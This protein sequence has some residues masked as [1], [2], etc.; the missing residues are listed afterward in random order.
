MKRYFLLF[1]GAFLVFPVFGQESLNMNLLYNWEDPS[2]PP[3]SAFNNPYNEVWGYEADGHEYAIVASTLGTHILDITDTDNVTEVDFVPGASQGSNIVH[4]DMHDY[5]GYLYMV[6]QEGQSTLQIADLSY[7]PDS[8]H[9]VYDS[10]ELIKGS[11]NIFIDTATA[12]L[13]AMDVIPASGSFIG[14][15]IISLEDPINPVL[16]HD[17]LLGSDV[18]DIFVRNDTAYLNRGGAS[19]ML[20]Y[21]FADTQN[22][23][24]LGSLTDYPGQGYNHAGYLDASGNTYVLADE[25]HGSPLKILDVSD[26]SDMEIVSTV[27]SGIASSSIPHNPIIHGDLM[28]SSYYY[29]GIYVWNIADPLNP[30]LV[31]FY[32]TSTIP[33]SN[34]YAGCWGV[35]PFLPS[36]KILASDM[37]NGLFVLE[38]DDTVTGINRPSGMPDEFGLFPNPSEGYVYLSFDNSLQKDFTLTIY[39][40]TGQKIYSERITQ[41]TTELDVSGFENGLYLVELSGE[42]VLTKM[43]VVR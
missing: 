29:D 22:P 41:S 36:G 13:Y 35:Y 34:G 19:L 15:R 37:Q 32:D 39:S 2:I 24:L 6:C 27:T 1:L 26:L 9:V 40:L 8:V 31:G 3:T 4:R 21:D 23:V 12:K 28:Y 7:L 11:H 43:L 16:L 5:N 42:S 25:T 20:V 10:N 33:N 17:M 38:L 18:H 14:L 30:Q